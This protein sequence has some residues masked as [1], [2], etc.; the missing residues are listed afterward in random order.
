VQEAP[1]QLYLSKPRALETELYISYQLHSPVSENLRGKKEAQNVS[2]AFPNTNQCIF[3]WKQP[4]E[5]DISLI[6]KEI[7]N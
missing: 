4:A 5:K 2:Q 7:H 1:N 6:L 3:H